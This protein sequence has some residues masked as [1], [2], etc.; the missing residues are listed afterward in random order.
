VV[1]NTVNSLSV[2]FHSGSENDVHY[3][4]PLPDELLSR[5]AVPMDKLHFYFAEFTIKGD[6]YEDYVKRNKE[7]TSGA[8]LGAVAPFE[9]ATVGLLTQ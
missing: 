1:S 4:Q 3:Y 2:T 8:P 5:F 9:I 7:G 6:S